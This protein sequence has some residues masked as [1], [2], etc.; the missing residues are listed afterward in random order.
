MIRPSA[1]RSRAVRALALC[2]TLACL[3]TATLAATQLTGSVRNQTHNQPAVG[4][5]VML[6]QLDAGTREESRTRTDALGSFK[7]SV[8]HPD[9]PYLVRVVHQGVAYEQR[10]SPGEALSIQVFD[11]APRVPGVTGSIEILRTGTNG[12][13]L[14]VSDM[15]EIQNASTPPLTLA[16]DRTFEAYLPADAKIDSVLAAGP[17]EIALMISAAPVPG[18]PGH[19][20]V[21]F[22]LRPGATKFAFNYD[23]PYAG[24]AAFRTRHAYPLRQFAVMIPPTMKFS[25]RSPAF[26]VLAT[27]NSR[28]QVQAANHLQAG[29]G[30]AFEIAGAG[31]LPSIADSAK[32]AAKTPQPATLTPPAAP[33]LIPRSS[34]ASVA[35][36]LAQPQ[37]SS[38]SILLAIFLTIVLVAASGLVVLCARKARSVPGPEMA[39]ASASH[40]HPSSGLL[41]SLQKE[42][43]QLEA[44]R[45]RGSISESEYVLT[46]RAI[47]TV[48]GPLVNR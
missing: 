40:A 12:N 21:N 28:Y 2:L 43:S 22:P 27:G 3:P 44:D 48:L 8:Q 5:D 38:Q 30:P 14:H 6:M 37:A 35:P 47:D 25:S 11:A 15:Y 9:K 13:L 36:R 46:K 7:L 33:A 29:E 39:A 31:A 17:G 23:V 10:A 4:D 32:P 1:A 20:T 18:D 41:T 26:K 42:L 24:H 45:R 34:L 16:S 19:F